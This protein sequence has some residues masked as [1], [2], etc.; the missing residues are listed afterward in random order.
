MRSCCCEVAWLL[1]P[2]P[3]RQGTYGEADGLEH[4]EQQP[5][6][7]EAVAAAVTAHQFVHERVMCQF[8]RP[9]EQDIEILERDRVDVTGGNGVQDL[10]RRH[11]GAAVADTCEVEVEPGGLVTH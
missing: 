4:F 1:V 6:L 5:V 10:Q 11:R 3:R 2:H 7:L 8:D 9:T